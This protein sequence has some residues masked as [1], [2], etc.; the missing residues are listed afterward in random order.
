MIRAKVLGHSLYE[1]TRKNVHDLAAL[2]GDD[3]IQETFVCANTN[4]YSRLTQLL[5]S[6]HL[7]L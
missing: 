1:V 2:L 7:L 4:N 3:L 6:Y 5:L